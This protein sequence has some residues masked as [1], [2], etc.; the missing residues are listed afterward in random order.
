[1]AIEDALTLFDNLESFGDVLE[2]GIDQAPDYDA[3]SANVDEASVNDT[4]K[5]ILRLS[6]LMREWTEMQRNELITSMIE[7]QEEEAQ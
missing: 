4:T 2:E 7:S 6:E 1:M 3:I 5:T